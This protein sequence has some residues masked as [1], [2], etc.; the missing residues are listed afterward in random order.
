MSRTFGDAEAKLKLYGGNPN[1]I[2]AEPDIK[3]F[4]ITSED[5]FIILGCKAYSI[6]LFLI[7]NL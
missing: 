1:V 2:I 5:D 6:F 3:S 4:E 7:N